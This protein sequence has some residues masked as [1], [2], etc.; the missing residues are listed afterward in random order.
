MRPETAA[1]AEN[2][3]LPWRRH[4]EHT[5][6]EWPASCEIPETLTRESGLKFIPWLCMLTEKTKST[7]RSGM[8]NLD[9]LV[10]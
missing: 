10:L 6:T 7:P 2:L 3:M 1:A 5:S 9:A 8:R 4:A